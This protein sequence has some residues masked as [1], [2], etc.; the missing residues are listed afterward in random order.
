MFLEFGQC[1][2]T[3]R[4]SIPKETIRI[5]DKTII[6][7]S[8]ETVLMQKRIKVICEE[9]VYTHYCGHNLSLVVVSGYKLQ[10]LTICQI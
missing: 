7:I 6:N 8:S 3:K 4:E 9:A 2:Q 5:L 1:K 10:L